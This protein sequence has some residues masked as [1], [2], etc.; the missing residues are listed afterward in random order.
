MAGLQKS[1]LKYALLLL[2]LVFWRVIADAAH[3]PG[4]VGDPRSV[5]Y[6]WK[7]AFALW[8][9]LGIE[10]LVFYL[11]LRR[12]GRFPLVFGLAFLLFLAVGASTPTC[13]PGLV[14]VPIQFHFF[15]VLLIGAAW[16]LRAIPP[17]PGTK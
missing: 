10:S 3:N 15:L 17:N 4:Y 1:F 14:Y 12:S 11:I 2:W 7:G 16:A 13:M 6:P 8:I 9:V 5:P